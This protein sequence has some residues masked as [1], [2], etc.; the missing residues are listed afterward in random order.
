M[1]PLR[2]QI[3]LAVVIAVFATV[4]GGVWYAYHKAYTTG[5]EVGRTEVEA[6]LAKAK[7]AW[8]GKVADLQ[9]GF[10]V[11]VNA[12]KEAHLAEIAK[13]QNQITYLRRNP[14]IVNRY[15]PA[16]TQCDITKGFVELHDTAAAGRPLADVP[17][18]TQS[19]NI[20]LDQVG[21]VI[22]DNYYTCN[23]IRDQLIGLQAIVRQYQQAQKELKK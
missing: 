10:D 8:E 9:L 11:A 19:T 1:I 3:A 2:T 14:T 20:R 22:A 23:Q 6:E 18:S 12:Q 7:A 17:K 4:G 15:I 5:Y 16:T 13:Y 21:T